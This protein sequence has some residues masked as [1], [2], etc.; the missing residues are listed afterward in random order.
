MISRRLTSLRALA[1]LLLFI[2]LGLAACEKHSTDK[3]EGLDQDAIMA[4][5]ILRASPATIDADAA[6]RD[7]MTLKAE[8]SAAQHC[9]ACHGPDLRGG[10][11]V[12]DLLDYEWIWGV[13][14]TEMN[15]VEPVMAIMQTLLYGI[16]NTDCLDDIKRYGACPDTRYSEMPA[17]G[18]LGFSEEQISDVVDYVLSLGG[19]EA[20]PEVLSR[21]QSGLWPYC[22][23]CHGDEGWG[24]KPY[25]GPDL[26]DDIWLYGGSREEIADVIRH[27][28]K[29]VC[30]PWNQVLDPAVI[31]ALAVYLY[32]KSM[33][34]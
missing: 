6:L 30:P 18:E 7:W 9:A 32:R 34:Y 25:G 22:T 21:A 12:P 23:E 10:T 3:E 14:G 1:L 16:R 11:G 31:K 4:D 19:A 29:G 24:F 20:E 26:S 15:E 13:S 33:G 28:R 27:G 2:L 17:Y 5:R 8:E